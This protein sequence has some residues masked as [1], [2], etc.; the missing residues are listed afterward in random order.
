MGS[1]TFVNCGELAHRDLLRLL[2]G[3][4]HTTDHDFKQKGSFQ[5]YLRILEFVRVLLSQNFIKISQ[6]IIFEELL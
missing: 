3:V 2:P 1:V 4:P 5:V 6:Q